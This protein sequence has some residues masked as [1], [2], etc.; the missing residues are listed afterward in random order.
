[1]FYICQT[2]KHNSNVTFSQMNLHRLLW[3]GWNVQKLSLRCPSRCAL[4]AEFLTFCCSFRELSGKQSHV[5]SDKGKLIQWTSDFCSSVILHCVI[6]PPS[7]HLQ[8]QKVIP[9]V[10]FV[11]MCV[12]VVFLFSSELDKPVSDLS[13]APL[14]ENKEKETSWVSTASALSEFTPSVC[15]SRKLQGRVGMY[16][17]ISVEY[18]CL[19]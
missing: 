11:W 13:V 5:L 12:R 18:V 8:N 4:L 17:V 1:M 6:T 19:N 14:T 10:A 2:H 15:K 9:D 16:A 7:Y 3:R